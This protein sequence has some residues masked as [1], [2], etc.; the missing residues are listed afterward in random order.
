MHA[1]P[2]GRRQAALNFYGVIIGYCAQTGWKQGPA[3]PEDGRGLSE[4][5]RMQSL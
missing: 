2:R 4:W 3:R 1:D 5:R